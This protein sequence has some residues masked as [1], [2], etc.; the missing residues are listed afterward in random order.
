M[1]LF[2]G[3]QLMELL[4]FVPWHQQWKRWLL[5]SPILIITSEK[6]LVE[7]L[8]P[9]ENIFLKCSLNMPAIA[10]VQHKYQLWSLLALELISVLMQYL[11]HIGT[12]A[13]CTPGAKTLLMTVTENASICCLIAAIVPHKS[14][15]LSVFN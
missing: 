4:L 6:Y 11:L 8:S 14:E 15:E 12:V 13:R 7:V 1:L 2:K 5:F 3:T 10:L 9:V